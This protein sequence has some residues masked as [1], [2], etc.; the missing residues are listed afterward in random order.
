VNI[1]DTLSKEDRIKLA[2]A[3]ALQMRRERW[4]ATLE[5]LPQPKTAMVEFPYATFDEAID[6]AFR[7]VGGDEAFLKLAKDAWKTKQWRKQAE[8]NRAA[9]DAAAELEAKAEI[10]K[11]DA[12]LGALAET[13]AKA[14]E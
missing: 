11:I 5:A 4:I 13:V 7:Q 8:K 12:E 1:I 2:T 14:I 10:E 6:D 3:Q 9:R